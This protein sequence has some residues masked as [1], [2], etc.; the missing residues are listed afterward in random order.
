MKDDYPTNSHYLTCTFIFQMLG[1]CTFWT[2]EWKGIPP[3]STRGVVSLLP[4]EGTLY[5]HTIHAYVYS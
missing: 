5:K 4:L 3:Q 2:W 1:E